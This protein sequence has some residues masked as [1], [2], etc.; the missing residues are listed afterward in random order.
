MCLD[1]MNFYLTAALKYFE[2]VKMPLDLFPTW[3]V[4]QYNLKKNSKNKWVYL[5][6]RCTMWGLP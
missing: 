4:D 2:Y 6:M 3:I 1:I 5:E